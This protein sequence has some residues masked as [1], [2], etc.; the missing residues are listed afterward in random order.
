VTPLFNAVRWLTHHL[1]E[2]AAEPRM[3]PSGQ[4]A[5]G[6]YHEPTDSTPRRRRSLN[7]AAHKLPVQVRA[8][9]RSR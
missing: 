8:H 3:P 2:A 7:E 1:T 9:G 5:A 4:Q 6:E